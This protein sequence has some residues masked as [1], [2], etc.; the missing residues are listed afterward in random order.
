[1]CQG[2]N[3]PDNLSAFYRREDH[4]TNHTVSHHL[5]NKAILLNLSWMSRNQ[6]PSRFLVA[7]GMA[8]SGCIEVF[9]LSWMY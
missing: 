1:M 9:F 7:H 3:R 2:N 4:S 6:K 5:V 8:R